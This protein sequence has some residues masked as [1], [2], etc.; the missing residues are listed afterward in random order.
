[1]VAAVE[2]AVL[3]VA[4]SLSVSGVAAAVRRELLARDALAAD[5]RRRQAEREADVILRPR[6]DGM[7]ELSVCCPQPLAAAIRDTLDGYA[8]LARDTGDRRPLGQLR[9]GVLADLVL[10]P[11]DTSGHRSPPT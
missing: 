5:A 8:H 11:W 4:G 2:A 1:V 6:P 9:V 7:A 3:P 10:R